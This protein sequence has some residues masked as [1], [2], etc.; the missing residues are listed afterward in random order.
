VPVDDLGALATAIAER[1]GEQ[2]GDLDDEHER[3]C[4]FELA[5]QRR[6]GLAWCFAPSG[7]SGTR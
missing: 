4:L 1:L 3:S 6:V 5:V 7:S 2:V